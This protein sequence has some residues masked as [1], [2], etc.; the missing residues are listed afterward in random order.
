MQMNQKLLSLKY[1]LWFRQEQHSTQGRSDV[2]AV[3]QVLNTEKLRVTLGQSL[4]GGEICR[5]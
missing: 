5:K 2:V 3:T 4:L 1:R